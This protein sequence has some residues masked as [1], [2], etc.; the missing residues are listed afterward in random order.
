MTL[1]GAAAKHC[2]WEPIAPVDF[3]SLP[4]D[5]SGQSTNPEMIPQQVLILTHE[6]ATLDTA[7]SLDKL[8][9]AFWPCQPLMMYGRSAILG[10]PIKKEEA[11]WY[12]WRDG[13]A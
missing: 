8:V 5:H 9:E 4:G 11:V 12:G 2:A 1:A 6:M 13:R 3:R 7:G 10:T